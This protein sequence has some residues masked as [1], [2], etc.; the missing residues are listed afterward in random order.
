MKRTNF[1]AITL[2]LSLVLSLFPSPALATEGAFTTCDWIDAKR[3]ERETIQGEF[4]NA[5]AASEEALLALGEAE[6]Q[7]SEKEDEVEILRAKAE[8]ASS[9]LDAAEKER[10]EKEEARNAAQASY[11]EA[12][13]KT[14]E[15]EGAVEQS[16]DAVNEANDGVTTSA[17]RV[18]E[19]RSAADDAAAALE[20]V[21]ESTDAASQQVAKGSVGFFEEMGSERA[22]LYL[23]DS[24]QLEVNTG[25]AF[26][27]HVHADSAVDAASLDN[28][29]ES[30]DWID[31][32]NTTYRIPNG[33]TELKVTDEIMG[34]SQRNADFSTAYYQH[35]SDMGEGY[36]EN[37]FYSRIG[38]EA[39]FQG[40]YDEE[41]EVWDALVAENP[42]LEQYKEN[43]HELMVND[44]DT[45][46]KV[47][48]Y[49]NII[50]PS[51]EITGL[52]LN[53]TDGNGAVIQQ[54]APADGTTTTYTVAEYRERFE[55]YYDDYV[56]NGTKLLEEAIAKKEDADDALETA[57]ALHEDAKNT[58]AAAEEQLVSSKDELAAAQETEAAEL[59]SLNLASQAYSESEEAV[60]KATEDY[61]EAKRAMEAGDSELADLELTRDEKQNDA[62]AAEAAEREA[63]EELDAVSKELA[64]ATDLS[65]SD[66]VSISAAGTTYDGTEKS[67]DLSVVVRMPDDTYVSLSE[68][69]DYDVAYQDNIN[70]G[71][72]RATITG[73]G[74]SESGTWWGSAEGT[75]VVAPKLIDDTSVTVDPVQNEPY[76]GTTI[77]PDICINDG[78][79]T[80][81]NGTDYVVV[82][83]NNVNAGVATGTVIGMGN[84]GGSRTV[85]FKIVPA[86]LSRARIKPIPNQTYTG[87]AICPTVTVLLDGVELPA[88]DY[89]VSYE[90][91]VNASSA[92]AKVTVTGK[93]NCFGKLSTTFS[94]NRQS[95]KWMKSGSRWWYQWADKSYP[96][97]QFLQIGKSTYY[98]D[99]SGWMAVGWK[100]IDGIWYY[101]SGS[102]SRVSGWQKI[103]GSW[104]VFDKDGKMVT[105]WW[106]E[107][108]TTYYLKS[109]GAMATGWLKAGNDWYWFKSSGAMGTGWLKDGGSWYWLDLHSGKMMTG[110]IS[111]SGTYYYL[112]SSGA[113][114]TGWQMIGSKWFFFEPSGAMA[115]SKWID[116]WYYVGPGGAMIEYGVVDGYRIVNGKWDGRGKVA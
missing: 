84:Y 83:E 48:H 41:K 85:E 52:A 86:D 113:M 102:G 28:L 26:S 72:A 65:N 90:N 55:Q 37:L 39:A 5:Q 87:K 110:W 44:P 33:L 3:S 68:D 91:N 79:K 53:T 24:E 100:Q 88:E 94:I 4:A 95:G 76:T 38:K 20:T 14:K 29:L 47:G 103:G 10:A 111:F 69:V 60:T 57:I 80:L 63:K 1:T 101:F 27:S 116:T 93:G 8:D 2:S 75:F 70:A 18:E 92:P 61:E 46:A 30:L 23:T 21:R 56:T 12:A 36:A 99:K 13:Q 49:L 71:T 50:D 107:G 34:S 78:E 89:D 22:A 114:A 11:D 35:A 25:T 15:A 77:E 67:V 62:D 40:W 32:C 9:S 81:I 106:K 16:Q 82:F 17:K 73:K 98:F 112:K 42:S 109:S 31:Y 19:A 66:T 74:D 104:Y 97:S 108:S 54:F 58:L 45:Y 96:T 105:G 7:L 59:E 51:W 43:A 64:D 6:K 115:K